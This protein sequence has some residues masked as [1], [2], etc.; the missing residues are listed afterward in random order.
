MVTLLY[1]SDSFENGQGLKPEIEVRTC[2]PRPPIPLSFSFFSSFFMAFALRCEFTRRYKRLIIGFQEVHSPKTV[3][4]LSLVRSGFAGHGWM[5][6]CQRFDLTRDLMRP[7][8][9]QPWVPSL[10]RIHAGNLG[11]L[12]MGILEWAISMI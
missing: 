1:L 5:S 7:Y 12:T 10:V 11:Q 8:L 3:L 4:A 6:E 2:L 9:V